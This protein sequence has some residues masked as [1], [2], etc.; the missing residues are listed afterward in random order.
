V[1][2]DSSPL[3]RADPLTRANLGRITTLSGLTSPNEWRR[4]ERLPPVP[5]GDTV[6]A[7]VNLAALGSDMTGAAPDGAGRPPM[8]QEPAPGVP[9]QDTGPG[10]AVEEG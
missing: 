10:D 5:G 4:S 7:P 1:F 9:N 6:R 8:G 3:L 2:L